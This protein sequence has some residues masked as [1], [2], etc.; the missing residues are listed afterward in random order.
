[1]AKRATSIYQHWFKRNQHIFQ[2]LIFASIIF[3]V[4]VTVLL[5]ESKVASS[6]GLMKIWFFDI[7][8][9]DAIFIEA[10]TGEQ[11]LID[12][13][14]SKSVSSKLGSVMLPWDRSIDALLLTHQDADHISGA[15]SVLENYQV[16]HVYE[17]GVTSSTPI[18]KAVAES[19]KNENS[20]YQIVNQG[21]VIELGQI[22]LEVLWP[23]HQA[24][25]NFS[26]E[27]NNTS[28]VIKLTYGELSVLL[29]GDLEETA[30]KFVGKLSGDIDV[31]KVAHHGSLSSTSNKFLGETTPEIAIIPVGKNNS[32][33]HPHPAVIKR[34][35]DRNI[36]IFRTDFD[37]DILL[38]SNGKS[39]G[40]KRVPLPF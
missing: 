30:E 34:L 39:I 13:G 38:V 22:K 7:G 12:A 23:N 35:I 4:S 20:I 17:N 31:L 27:R 26:K 11:M 16:Q 15:V 37:E 14:P 10:P 19:I 24:L 2:K 29:T 33:G 32:Y 6:N 36:R 9:G 25:D 3:C 21:D 28:I 18:S 1:M 8:Q 5:V 40:V